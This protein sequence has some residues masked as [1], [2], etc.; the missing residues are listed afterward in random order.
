MKLIDQLQM[1]YHNSFGGPSDGDVIASGWYDRQTWNRMVANLPNYDYITFEE[2]L[3]VEAAVR[4]TVMSSADLTIDELL[5]LVTTASHLWRWKVEPTY[6]LA[7]FVEMFN[8]T[9]PMTMFTCC[10]P[11]WDNYVLDNLNTSN[12]GDG[13]MTIVLKRRNNRCKNL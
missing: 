3:S 6:T 11:L 1:Y 4:S 8:S 10:N 7:Q 5:A 12:D 2:M 9:G 13:S